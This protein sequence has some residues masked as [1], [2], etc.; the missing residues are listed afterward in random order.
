MTGFERPAPDVDKIVAAWRTWQAGGDDVLPG[1]TMADLK[2]GGADRVIATLAADNAE[3]VVD[4]E[5]TWAAWE[6][7]RVG[8]DD[9]LAALAENGFADIVEALAATT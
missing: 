9:T 7:G 6:K 4:V 5:A 1:R 3:A 2:I 8:P